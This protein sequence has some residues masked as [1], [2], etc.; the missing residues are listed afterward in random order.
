MTRIVIQNLDPELLSSFLIFD[1]FTQ[2]F[3]NQIT[4]YSSY[5]NMAFDPY[6]FIFEALKRGQKNIYTTGVGVQGPN[7]ERLIG[8]LP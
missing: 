1:C 2:A 8:P 6:F 5:S 4:K 3:T 7:R